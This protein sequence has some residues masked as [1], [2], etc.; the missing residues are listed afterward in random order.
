MGLKKSQS[1]LDTALAT[2]KYCA[3][4]DTAHGEYDPTSHGSLHN[5][6]GCVAFACQQLF[7]WDIVQGKINGISHYWNRIDKETEVDFCLEQFGADSY[8]FKFPV[9]RLT[10]PRKHINKRF[11]KFWNRV[12]ESYY[13]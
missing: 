4:A 12:Q 8:I 5:H 6:C 7:G 10:K 3:S 1:N 11:L 2:F 13:Q 9:G